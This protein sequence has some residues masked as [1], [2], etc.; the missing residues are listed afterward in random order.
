MESVLNKMTKAELDVVLREL[1]R[2]QAALQ[3]Q[4]TEICQEIKEAEKTIEKVKLND[5]RIQSN[6]RKIA[7]AMGKLEASKYDARMQEVQER[8]SHVV[9]ALSGELSTRDAE[10]TQVRSSCS[11]KISNGCKQNEVFSQNDQQEFD[12]KKIIFISS[13]Q[14]SVN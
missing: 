7:H 4:K 13:V 5:E 2:E 12:G 14:A 6:E 1:Q 9:A 3:K 10:P 8:I 11:S